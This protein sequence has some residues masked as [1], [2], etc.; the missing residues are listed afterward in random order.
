MDEINYLAMDDMQKLRFRDGILALYL[1]FVS[2]YA[3]NL[4]LEVDR[5]SYI[6]EQKYEIAQAYQDLINDLKLLDGMAI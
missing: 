4:Q 1:P 2:T 5:D 3:L 6:E